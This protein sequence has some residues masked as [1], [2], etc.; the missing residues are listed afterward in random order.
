MNRNPTRINQNFVILFAFQFYVTI[1]VERWWFF[2]GR[3]VHGNAEMQNKT[4]R[5]HHVL[6][7]SSIWCASLYDSINFRNNNTFV[8]DACERIDD[9][10]WSFLLWCCCPSIF[11]WLNGCRSTDETKNWWIDVAEH[12]NN[13]QHR[14]RYTIRLIGNMRA[15]TVYCVLCVSVQV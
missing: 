1:V 15:D 8:C 5:R 12:H 3:Q 7:S 13:K 4:N 11:H 9:V 6:S 14:V 2:A 10:K